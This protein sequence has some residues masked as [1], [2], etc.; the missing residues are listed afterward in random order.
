MMYRGVGK[1]CGLL[2]KRRVVAKS[3]PILALLASTVLGFSAIGGVSD[4]AARAQQ[5]EAAIHFSIPAQSLSSAVDAF[6]RA[7]GW[8]VGYSSAI[9]RSTKT[10]EVSGTMSPT[11]ALQ[12]ML[13]GTN[14]RVRTTGSASAALVDAAELTNT[15]G[16]MD[17]STVLEPITVQGAGATTEG[18]GSYTTGEMS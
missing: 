17:G 16:P 4:T 10:R 12:V 18:T 11:R 1:D 13:A 6:S 9:A 7:T 15:T 2:T 14:V 5:S 3:R 8:Q